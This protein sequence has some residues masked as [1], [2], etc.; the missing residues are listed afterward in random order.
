M[1]EISPAV[2]QALATYEQA[3]F[4][5]QCEAIERERVER[6]FTSDLRGRDYGRNRRL[7]YEASTELGLWREPPRERA[8]TALRELLYA[9][10]AEA[11]AML[12]VDVARAEMTLAWRYGYDPGVRA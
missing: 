3:L 12:A 11:R 5:L 8:L 10:V 4:N 6:R 9:R 2:E 7:V 1:I